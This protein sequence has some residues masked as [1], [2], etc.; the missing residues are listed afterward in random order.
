MTILLFA[1]LKG[2]EGQVGETVE[3][4]VQCLFNPLMSSRNVVIPLFLFHIYQ[5][6]V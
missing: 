6:L 2:T 4:F 1:R 3:T 5:T